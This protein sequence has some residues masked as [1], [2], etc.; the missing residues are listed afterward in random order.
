MPI[1]TVYPTDLAVAF[2]SS[3]ASITSHHY[4]VDISTSIESY[5]ISSSLKSV[6]FY[7]YNDIQINTSSSNDKDS[8]DSSMEVE[9]QFLSVQSCDVASGQDVFVLLLTLYHTDQVAYSDSVI[10][11]LYI[12]DY[13]NYDHANIILSSFV[14]SSGVTDLAPGSEASLIQ[15]D[16]VDTYLYLDY[17]YITL[18]SGDV[19]TELEGLRSSSGV[20]F[21]IFISTD[22][23]QS[24]ESSMVSI[25]S[26][27]GSFPYI[28][29][30]QY[31][32]QPPPPVSS[33]TDVY[34]SILIILN[35]SGIFGPQSCYYVIDPDSVTMWPQGPT[36]FCLLEPNEVR[37]IGDDLGGGRN[38]KTWEVHFTVH[39][40]VEN[41]FDAAL[42]DTVVVTSIDLSSG[43][44]RIVDQ[45]IN[46]MEQSYP[47]NDYG[48]PTTIEYPRFEQI[49]S[50]KRYSGTNTYIG[51]PVKFYCTFREVLPFSLP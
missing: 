37:N 49:M 23:F 6:D 29:C 33:L 47:L 32:V 50:L 7:Q 27:D 30:T 13:I 25:Q 2:E 17:Q 46:M 31:T 3:S 10:K 24:Q 36:P 9:S 26:A 34:E 16:Q 38:V 42:Q 5:L 41:V 19:A 18:Y 20:V 48:Y 35:N 14:S 51:L 22:N 21:N 45:L 40:V 1:I 39:I 44:Y 43:P 12:G 28:E 4:D 11:Y 8:T 15:I